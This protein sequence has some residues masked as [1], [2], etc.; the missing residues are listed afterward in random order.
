MKFFQNDW[1]N[2][3]EEEFN[4]EY[5]K[6]IINKVDEA[7]AKTR[8]YPP[9]N[10]IFSA[11]KMT[12]YKDVKVVILGQDPYHEEGQA[13]GLCFSVMPAFVS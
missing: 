3:L 1:D 8:V 10:K 2:V 7:Y 9:R 6:Q 11:F 12:P 4:K 5:F 13:H